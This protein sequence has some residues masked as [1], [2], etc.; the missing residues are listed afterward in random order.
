MS[1]ETKTENSQ[2]ETK[3]AEV[4]FTQEDVDKIVQDRLAREKSRYKDYDEI[5]RQLG[6]L[7]SEKK[8]REEAEL[9]E[10]QRLARDIE[11]LKAE[12]KELEAHKLWRESWEAQ[13]TEKIN[14]AMEGFE[15]EDKELVNSL[16]L[17]K[18]IS[19]INKLK[20]AKTQGS[21]LGDKAVFMEKERVPTFEEAQ[22]LKKKYGTGSAQYK[23][24]LSIREKARTRGI[25]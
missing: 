4:T 19:M 3:T 1:D 24:A 13:E 18:R 12:K 8:E 2:E 9:S 17:D 14:N 23:N 5:K 16:P 21:P 15:D 25:I 6:T 20:S 22:E 7:L 10:S 11:K